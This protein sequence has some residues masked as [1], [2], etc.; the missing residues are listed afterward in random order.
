M[1]DFASNGSNSVHNKFLFAIAICLFANTLQAAIIVV[2]DVN[3]D[4]GPLGNTQFY[5][6]V[7]GTSTDVL[8]G[9]GTPQG[10]SG[11]QSLYSTTPGVSVTVGS[12]TLTN[13]LL[14][15]FDLLVI[16]ASFEGGLTFT[17]AELSAVSGFLANGGDVLLVAEAS[18]NAAAFA[19]YNNFLAGIGSTIRYSG[20]RVSQSTVVIPH[21]L[22][23]GVTSFGMAAEDVLTGGTALVKGTTGLTLVAYESTAA[24]PEPASLIIWGGLG[25]AGLVAARR[26]KKVAA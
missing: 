25:I 20:V 15:G 12:P 2:G 16:N 19:S 21:P 23:T 1:S 24:V 6:N 5:Q 11:I 9:R 8:F 17:G 4:A 7:L 14:S 22:T 26:R 10:V 13:S 18:N 3:A